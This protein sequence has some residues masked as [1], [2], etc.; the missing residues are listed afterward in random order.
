MM[1]FTNLVKLLLIKHLI[2]QKALANCLNLTPSGVNR[3]AAVIQTEGNNNR[4][5]DVR[6][7]GSCEL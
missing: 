7:V 6:S 3:S 2:S 5:T 1:F 4:R